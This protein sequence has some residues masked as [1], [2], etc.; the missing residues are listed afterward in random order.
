MGAAMSD[1]LGVP[2]GS[3]PEPTQLPGSEIL[4]HSAGAT[5]ITPSQTHRA[6]GPKKRW[7]LPAVGASVLMLA[8]ASAGV[9]LGVMVSGGGTQPEELVPANAM[10]YADVDF[11]PAA[12]QKAN[13][14]RLINKFPDL[15]DQLGGGD[16]IKQV[17]V[18]GLLDRFRFQCRQPQQRRGAQLVGRPSRSIAVMPG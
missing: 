13:L 9:A 1:E 3:V 14:M 10:I 15:Q 18:E 8:V 16:D 2:G 7:V 17:I 12:G 6:S 4:D 5:T 11:D